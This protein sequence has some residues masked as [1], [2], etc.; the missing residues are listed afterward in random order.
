[1]TGDHYV[2]PVAANFRQGIPGIVHR[3]SSTGE[4]LYIE[5]AAIAHP[6]FRYASDSEH[7]T[8]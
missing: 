3:T 7:W 4:T 5:P 6:S 8:R 2:L 1:V